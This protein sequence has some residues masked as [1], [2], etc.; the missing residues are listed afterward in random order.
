M[1]SSRSAAGLALLE[2]CLALLALSAGLL[3]L[4]QLQLGLHVFVEATREG[5]QAVQLAQATLERQR[6]FTVLEPE[7]GA[8]AYAQVQTRTEQVEL[9]GG[10]GRTAVLELHV[11]DQPTLQHKAAR[12]TVS[13]QDRHGQPRSVQLHTVIAGVPP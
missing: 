3:T 5:A 2:A 8:T 12:V 7:A 13:W 4:A 11:T 6:R 9:P 10:G 1:T